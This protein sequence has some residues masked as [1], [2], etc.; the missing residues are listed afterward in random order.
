MHADWPGFLSPGSQRARVMERFARARE[1]GEF[2]VGAAIGAGLL[3]DAAERGGADFLVALNAGRFR[4]MGASSVACIL[5][6]RDANQFV[7]SFAPLEILSQ[8]RIPVYF[9]AST[10]DP[11]L[12]LE[13]LV[14]EIA[15]LGFAGVANFPSV[16]HLPAPVRHALD[17]PGL[18]FERELELLALAHR[19]DLSSLAYV[20]TREQASAAAARGVDI[21]CYNVGWN[22]GGAKGPV[23]EISVEETAAHAREMHGVIRRE[24]PRAFFFLEGG[25]IQ[26][27]DQLAAV[28]RVA[29]MHGYI[30]GSTIDR[31]PLAQSV[32]GQTQRFKS[33][34]ALARILGKQERMLVDLGRRHGFVGASE[35]MIDVYEAL[36][37]F[38]G[39]SFPMLISGERNTGR[40]TLIEALHG[41][42]R[43]RRG[44]LAVIEADDG[45]SGRQAMIALFGRAAVLGGAGLE[46]LAS[47]EDIGMIA[48]RGIE[49]V[50]LRLQR[51]LAN[52]LKRGRFVPFGDR[53]G[54]PWTKRLMLVS[55][56]SLKSLLAEGRIDPQ[57]AELLSGHE[58]RLPPLRKRTEDIEDLLGRFMAGLAGEGQP[59]P[60]LSPGAMSLLRRH[61]WP[62]N[63]LE[64]RSF[65]S[66]LFARH[67]AGRVDEEAALG[68]LSGD[69]D[70]MRRR[71]SSERDILLDALW[72]HGFHRGKTAAFLGISRK[73]L[74]NKIRRYRLTS[75]V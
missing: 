34:T 27:P 75:Q 22:A 25:P 66:R 71:M 20:R 48:L 26:D 21:I 6:I 65:A 69:S 52:T 18:G 14:A 30:G 51:R 60:V 43:D 45:N 47:R 10:L 70:W 4:L 63:L 72:R 31:L 42:S 9:G 61:D 13:A 67:G 28:C 50:P 74:Y 54:Q 44:S 1:R 17:G 59:Y 2:L 32:S 73:T 16:V 11:A 64:L 58:I 19:H 5:P 35:A 3:G 40:Q 37:R 23:S 41:E 38:R 7:L 29:R 15:D 57:L 46:G 39:S 68:L 56:F 8:C 49:H 53:R 36:D 62:G 55:D 12:S 24:N 33:A